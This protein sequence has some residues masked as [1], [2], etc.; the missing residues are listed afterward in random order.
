MSEPTAVK[1]SAFAGMFSQL[2]AKDRTLLLILGATSFFDGYDRGILSLALRQIRTSFDL[3]QGQASLWLSILFLGALPALAVTRWSDR[4]GRRRMLL[5]SIVG[6]TIATGLTAAAPSIQ[7]YVACQFVARLFLN[8]EAAIVWTMAAEELPAKAR[9]LGFGVLAMNAALGVGFGAIVFGGILEPMGVSWRVMYLIG[10]PPLVAIGFLRRKLPESKRFVAARD[11][12]HL[13]ERWH[14]IL[15]PHLRRSLVLVLSTAFLFELT[16]QAG[17]FAL[18]FLQSSRG[19]SAMASNFMLVA[20]GLP[21]IPIMVMAGGLSD[22]YGRRFIGS[23]FGLLSLLGAVGFFWLP[24]GIPVLLPCL[25]LVTVG[26]LGSWPVLGGYAME[27]FPTSVRSQAGAWSTVAKVGGNASSLAL[28][29]VLIQLTGGL[30]TAAMILGLGP[31]LG[32]VIILVAFPETHGRELEEVSGDY[33][34]ILLAEHHADP[35][36]DIDALGDAVLP[37]ALARAAHDEQAAGLRGEAH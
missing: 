23:G 37:G 9:G 4:I 25:M 1:P 17:V 36:S 34:L 27:M 28:G 35:G 15:Q 26:S 13:A 11:Q 21:G 22:R 16:T 14:E 2:D 29:G 30:P 12:G 3:S 31:L 18:D 5:M 7:A 20:A 8:A 33:P 24:G 32:I 6:Y 10:V 19:I